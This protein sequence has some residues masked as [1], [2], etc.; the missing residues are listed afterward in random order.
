[1]SAKI[2]RRRT[3]R[4]TSV[5]DHNVVA[6]RIRPGHAA[7]LVDVSAGGALVETNCRLLPGTDVELHVDTPTKRTSVR[8]RVLRCAVVHVRAW[9]IT[10][11]G[12]INFDRHLPWL[13]DEQGY[14][15]PDAET[16]SGLGFRAAATPEVG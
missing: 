12:A 16:R 7:Q 13:A 11:R 3:K 8:G 5:E 1:M 14:G 10:Y 4:R 2:D 15:V 9:G 6:V